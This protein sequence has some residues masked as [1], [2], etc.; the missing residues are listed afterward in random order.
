MKRNLVPLLV[1]AFVVAIIST[2]IFYGL[3]VGKL[4][5]SGSQTGQSIVVAARSLERGTLLQQTD[6]RLAAWG[7]AALPKGAFTSL[8]QVKNA[9]V[10][11]PLQENEPL[12]SARVASHQNGTG[13]GLGVAPGMRAVSLRPSDSSGVLSILRPGHKVDIQLVSNQ[14]APPE[15]RTI[16]QN[17][18]VLNV[19]VQPDSRAGAAVVTL[20]ADPEGADMIA[21]GDSAARVRLTLRNPLDEG[22]PSLP[23]LTLQPMF[24][25]SKTPGRPAASKKVP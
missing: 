5:A 24:Q 3:F 18:E 19:N 10:V 8:D 7:A 22:S 17:I 21:L 25:Q 13:A 4:R 12:L 1:I 23:R 9:T 20:L 6:V 16:L 11:Q 15:L 2:G 14:G